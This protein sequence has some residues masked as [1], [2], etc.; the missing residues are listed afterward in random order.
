[1]FRIER[2]P[3]ERENLSKW[4]KFIWHFEADYSEVHHKLLPMNSIDI[5]I[6]LAEDMIYETQNRKITA[7]KVHVNGLRSQHSFLYQRGK[8]DVWGI[9]F[10][11]FGLY[12]FINKSL[13]NIQNEIIDLNLL[14]KSLADKLNMAVREKTT[15]CKI[16]NILESLDSELKISDSQLEKAE[17]ISAF[18]QAEDIPISLFC[19]DNGINQRTF[20]RFVLKMTGYTPVNLRKIRRYQTASNQLLLKKYDKM[21]EIVYDNNY[22]DQSHFNKDFKTYSGV[23]PR[24]FQ[25]EKITII[26]NTDYI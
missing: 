26:E 9:S 5:V 12:P 14:S 18:M 16:E 1:M 22:T 21:P 3:I 13:E 11:A 4:V 24:I 25:K 23:S 6:N 19:L 7:P 10:Y 20:E 15:Q 2:Y 17:L 8:I